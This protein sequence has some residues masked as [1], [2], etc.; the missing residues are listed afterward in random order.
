MS[1]T[2]GRLLSFRSGD[3]AEYLALFLVSRFAFINPVPR[4]EDFGL[5]DFVCFVGREKAPFY[6]AEDAFLLQIK[7]NKRKIQF[8]SD[9]S[10]YLKK[11]IDLP[12]IICISSPKKNLIQFY[13]SWR[14]WCYLSRPETTDISKI[15]LVFD[16][17]VL[18]DGD[19]PKAF[20]VKGDVLEVT[21][22][23]PILSVEQ[24]DLETG[25]FDN[26][27]NLIKFWLE[28][29]R[30][31]I[32][33]LRTGKSLFYGVENWEPNKKPEEGQVYYHVVPQLQEL[34]K[35]T[36]DWLTSLCFNYEYKGHDGKIEIIS[37]FLKTLPE[38]FFNEISKKYR[39]WKSKV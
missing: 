21:L 6:H 39:D 36:V 29:E 20:T 28:I 34:E 16:K 11:H 14:L 1:K 35:R 37:E 31:N 27:Y 30:L 25:N 17:Y 7:S 23:N 12:L 19:N 24:N 26:I 3:R 38:H 15:N 22:G 33:G 8:K 2:K 5:A 10:N 13:S 18:S 4:Q 9:P 32:I